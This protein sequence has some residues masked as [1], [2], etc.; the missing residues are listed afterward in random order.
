LGHP[1]SERPAAAGL[2]RWLL[3]PLVIGLCA[4]YIAGLVGIALRLR[5]LLDQTGP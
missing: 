3:A 5:T 2:A 1:P 4:L